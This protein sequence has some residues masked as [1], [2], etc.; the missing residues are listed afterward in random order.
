MKHH[1]FAAR[2][3]IFTFVAFCVAT[4][5][6]AQ[7]V[8]DTVSEDDLRRASKIEPTITQR[9]MD[10]ASKVNRQPTAAEI[11][12]ASL[13]TPNVDA[14]PSA[15]GAS[16]SVDLA[17]IAKGF[18]QIEKKPPQMYN[19][20]LSLL[21]FVSFSMPEATL[22]RL[23]DQA[24]RS[25]STLLVRGFHEGSLKKT[26]AKIKT[27]IGERKNISIQIDPQAFDRFAI[28]R[29]PTFVMVKPGALPIPCAAGTCVPPAN[30]VS[31]SGDV[32]I[33]YALEFFQRSSP[34]FAKDASTLLAKTRRTR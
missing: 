27:I 3:S 29:A 20:K 34:A 6:I 33:E 9:D 22:K 15:N 18:E 16:K 14:L 32:S 7:P 25:E 17:D 19:D 21:V 31:A 13:S 24:S 28:T 8:K 4:S 30:F 26:M 23:V 10:R 2:A 11:A 12:G 5:S 1:P